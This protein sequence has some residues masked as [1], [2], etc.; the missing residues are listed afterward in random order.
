MLAGQLSDVGGLAF[1]AADVAT[2][3]VTFGVSGLG[4]SSQ[5]FVRRVGESGLWLYDPDPCTVVAALH[6]DISDS[7]VA[8][9]GQVIS[10]VAEG[11]DAASGQRATYEDDL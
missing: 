5:E 2:S 9:A 11:A 1:S 3:F 6:G 7:D 8:T 4:I 10:A